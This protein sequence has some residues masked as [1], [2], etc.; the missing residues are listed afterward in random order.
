MLGRRFSYCP[1]R[2]KW[3]FTHYL[4]APV[5]ANHVIRVENATRSQYPPGTC[6]YSSPSPQKKEQIIGKTRILQPYQITDLRKLGSLW[7]QSRPNPRLAVESQASM[8]SPQ[9]YDLQHGAYLRTAAGRLNGPIPKH[10]RPP[11]NIRVGIVKENAIMQNVW[12]NI[13]CAD[14]IAQALRRAWEV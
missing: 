1:H 14:E 8:T 11:R 12:V 10:I 4:W 7:R 6:G 13:L 9:A 2:K 3:R 5:V